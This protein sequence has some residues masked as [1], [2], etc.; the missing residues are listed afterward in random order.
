[1]MAIGYGGNYAFAMQTDYDHE[2]QL[3]ITATGFPSPAITLHHLRPP[4]LRGEL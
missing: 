3:L 1:M 2:T 4:C